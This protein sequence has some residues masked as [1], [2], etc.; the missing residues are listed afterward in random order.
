[1]FTAASDH[2]H[3]SLPMQQITSSKIKAAS[4]ADVPDFQ[5]GQSI[6]KMPP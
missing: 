1:M 3:T 4:K 5:P 6:V 2:L